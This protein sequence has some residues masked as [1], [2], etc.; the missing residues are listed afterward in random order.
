MKIETLVK[1]NALWHQAMPNVW[2]LG[3]FIDLGVLDTIGTDAHIR[4]Q[5]HG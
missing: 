2:P 3:E 5:G 1:Y 4:P